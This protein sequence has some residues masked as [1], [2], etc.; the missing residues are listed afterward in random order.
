MSTFHQ[1]VLLKEATDALNVKKGALYIDATAGGGGHTEEISKRGGTVLAIDR[2][3]QALDYLRKI[4]QKN[5]ILVNDNFSHIKSIAVKFGFTNVSGVIFD[6]GVS[7]HQL[8]EAKRGFSFQKEGPLDMRMDPTLQITAADLINNFERRRLNEIIKDFGQ[9]KL[10]WPIAGA[11]SSARQLKKI[12]STKELAQIVS[13]VYA[14]Y[15]VRSKLHPAT[16]T[17]QALRIVV[18]SELL[19]LQEALP[20]TVEILEKGGRLAVISFHSLE[21]AIVKRFFK[22]A[23]RLKTI[24]KTPIGPGAGEI[25][26]NPRS[27]SAKLRVAEK[28]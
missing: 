17:F 10:S 9:E 20:Q 13:E 19:N 5:V 14:K 8:D 6:L 18:N 26:K 27:R 11:I 4:G 25:Q 12:D 3:P 21:D 23:A 1:S 15:H 7:S 24:T 28:I 16:K 22:Q 2:D